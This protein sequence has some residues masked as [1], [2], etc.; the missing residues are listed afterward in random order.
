MAVPPK[1][2]RGEFFKVNKKLLNILA[3]HVETVTPWLV[4]QMLSATKNGTAIRWM[5]VPKAAARFLLSPFQ[6]RS[7]IEEAMARQDA[8]QPAGRL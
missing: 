2:Q 8:G 3:D 7:V 5:S 1:S 6:K 4:E